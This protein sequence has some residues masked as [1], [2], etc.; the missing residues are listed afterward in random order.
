MASN[1]VPLLSPPPDSSFFLDR[2]GSDFDEE[3]ADELESNST[4]HPTS[5]EKLDIVSTSSFVFDHRSN[6]S[7]RSAQRAVSPAHYEDEPV[8]GEDAANGYLPTGSAVGG[9]TIVQEEIET[10]ITLE[11]VSDPQLHDRSVS[12]HSS[13]QR[14]LFPADA[15]DETLNVQLN[16]DEAPIRV[17][18]PELGLD[19]VDV[20]LLSLLSEEDRVS[21]SSEI[22]LTELKSWDENWLFKQR[23]KKANSV[24]SYFAFADLD[25]ASEPV[26][27]F[28]PNP[29]HEAKASIG[30]HGVD[31]LTDL[32]EKNSVASLSFSSDSE[33]ESERAEPGDRKTAPHQPIMTQGGLHKQSSHSRIVAD[34]D[35]KPQAAHQP[36]PS[37]SGEEGKEKLSRGQTSVS[38]SG[39]P[40]SSLVT[41]CGENSEKTGVKITAAKES[42][43]AGKVQQRHDLSSPSSGIALPSFVPLSRRMESSRSDP[44]FVIK[45]CGASVQ[46]AILVQF[47]CRVRGSRPL[48]VAWFKGDHLLTDSDCFRIFSSGNEFVLEIRCTQLQ[49]SDVY[50]CV[51]YNGFGEQWAD[52]SLTVKERARSPVTTKP[53]RATVSDERYVIVTN[54]SMGSFLLLSASVC[55][56]WCERT[57]SCVRIAG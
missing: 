20:H 45:P 11:G 8:S 46:T 50:S 42:C 49:H 33:S 43:F 39:C 37:E 28:I 3:D 56:R 5:P 48:G 54:D 29:S 19:L 15:T 4:S 52:F 1:P 51:V 2:I 57:I 12:S 53:L 55:R 36:C 7:S 9:T 10:I 14:N 13:A 22:R 17:P 38:S 18:F 26:R 16:V 35:H 40:A 24:S 32:S 23:K 31:D 34:A 30:Q 44:C 25:F 41:F 27:M 6:A 47:C 21:A